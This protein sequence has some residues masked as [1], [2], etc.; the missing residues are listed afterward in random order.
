MD[1]K[2]RNCANPT[3]MIQSSC[4]M[5]NHL[6]LNEYAEKITASVDKVIADKRIRTPDVGGTGKTSEFCEAVLSNLQ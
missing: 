3:A 2:D 5:L 4:W 6:G 1:I